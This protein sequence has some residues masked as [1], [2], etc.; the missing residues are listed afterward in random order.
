MVLNSWCLS[1][2]VCIHMYSDGPDQHVLPEHLFSV[3][4]SSDFVTVTKVYHISS[5]NKAVVS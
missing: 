1:R 2:R 3:S 5:D 4:I